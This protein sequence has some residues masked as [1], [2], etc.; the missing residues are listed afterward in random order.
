MHWA[1]TVGA[2]F[3]VA[4]VAACSKPIETPKTEPAKETPRPAAS[5]PTS[6]VPAPPREQEE[7]PAPSPVPQP[8]PISVRFRLYEGKFAFREAQTARSL[9]PGDA[10]VIGVSE[11]ALDIIFPGVSQEIAL[12]AVKVEGVNLAADPD[13]LPEGGL[14]LILGPGASG[15]KITITVNLP[16]TPTAQLYLTRAKAAQVLVDLRFLDEWRPVTIMNSY[17]SPGSGEIRISFSKPVIRAEVEKALRSAQAAPVR[18]QM[19]W[20]DDQTLIWQVAVL[21]LRLDFLLGG[22]H[23]Q[24]GLPLPGGVPSVRAGSPPVLVEVNLSDPVDLVRAALPPDI[25]SAV[26][27]GS[28]EHINLTAWSPGTTRWDWRTVDFSISTKEWKLKN[29]HVS[30]VQPRLPGNLQFWRLNPQGTTVGGLRPRSDTEGIDLLFMDLRGGRQQV[31]PNFIRR[32]S[33]PGTPDATSYL[34]W[35]TDGGEIAALT[36]SRDPAQSDLII[37]KVADGHSALEMAGLPVAAQGSRVEWSQ[38]GRFI[39]VGNLLI[40]LETKQTQGLPGRPNEARGTWEPGGG[41][42]LLYQESEWGPIWV[43]NPLAGPPVPFGTGIVVDWIAPDRVYLVR[44]PSSQGRYVP[45]G[46]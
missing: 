37:F 13:L 41:A 29:G 8:K 19:Y 23:D 14:S 43:I 38:S 21:P 40:D 44:W 3:L 22:A 6:T 39:L 1:R 28:Q 11:R 26:L 24:D 5:S 17:S 31:V 18:G 36:P 34:A 7:A 42:R 32:S 10:T 20:L 16:G 45:P 33:I 25:I 2:L 4:L 15:D 12:S 46:F 9:S 27:T 30:G 35:S